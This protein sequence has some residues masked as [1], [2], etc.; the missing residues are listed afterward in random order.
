VT[1]HHSEGGDDNVPPSPPRRRTAL[2][3]ALAELAAGVVEDPLGSN[4]G[5][6]W[7]RYAL[8]GEDPLAWCARFVRWCFIEAGHPLPGNRYMIG[9]VERM[10][11]ELDDRGA[12][13]PARME[14]QPGD[15]AFW[16]DRGASDAGSGRHVD[17]VVAAGALT[18]TVVGGNVSHRVKRRD[19]ARHPP[20]LW[21]FARWPLRPFA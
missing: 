19:T 14:P 21:C 12:I 17:L 8:P 20:G 13:L 18:M 10:Q 15:L 4:K 3:Y 6:P 16:L 7:T 11:R 1:R 9:N 2:D 5:I